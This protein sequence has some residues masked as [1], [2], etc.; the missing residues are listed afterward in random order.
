M[1]IGQKTNL[2]FITEADGINL[3]PRGL[4]EADP[5]T[6]A[7]SREG[8]FAG[9]DVVSGPYIAI[10][11]VAAGREAAVSIDR[12]LNGQDLQAEREMP[13]RPVS[14][15]SG[16]WVAVPKNAAK[17]P[18][19]AMPELPES[20]WLKGFAEINQ[21]YPEDQAMAEAERCLNCG[22]CSECMQCVT[23]CQAGAIDHSSSPGPGR[24]RWG[25]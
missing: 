7:T 25:P 12:Y 6:L 16:N 14:P 22:G 5:E 19:A 13:L 15:E 17:N 3:T 2:T 20:E 10:A 23:A 11:A 18:R 9:G 21:G 1:A 24:L 8:V 4:I